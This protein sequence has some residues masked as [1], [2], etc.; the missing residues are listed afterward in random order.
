MEAM[1]TV[2]TVAHLLGVLYV[3]IGLSMLMRQVKRS[4]INC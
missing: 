1:S 2:E 3:V 4:F